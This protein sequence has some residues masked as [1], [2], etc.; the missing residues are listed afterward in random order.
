MTALIGLIG[1]IPTRWK[2]YLILAIISVVG[3]FSV[4]WYIGHLE[5]QTEDFKLLFEAYMDFS[6]LGIRLA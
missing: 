4:K 2:I 1:L 6:A 3:F 5:N